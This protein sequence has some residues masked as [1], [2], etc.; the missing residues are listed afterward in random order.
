MAGASDLELCLRRS[1][2]DLDQSC[3][4]SARLLKEVTNVCDLFWHDE[5]EKR[6]EMKP[7]VSKWKQNRNKIRRAVANGD[8]V[9]IFLSPINRNVAAQFS[10]Q[11]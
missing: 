9:V 6:R 8:V 1:L 5:T 4:A 3:V 2:S 7:R 11:Q 10:R